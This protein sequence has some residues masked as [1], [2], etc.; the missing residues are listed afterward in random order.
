[1]GRNTELGLVNAVTLRLWMPHGN[2]EGILGSFA[3]ALGAGHAS[4][5][6]K[7]NG[8][9]HYITWQV[10]QGMP[11]GQEQPARNYTNNPMTKHIDEGYMTNMG[12]GAMNGASRYANNAGYLRSECTHKIRL[13]TLQPNETR[14]TT[15]GIDANAI[16]NWWNQRRQTETTYQL[17]SKTH[18]CTGCVTEALHA[19]G[20]GE[21]PRATFVVT[22][23]DVLNWV[24]VEGNKQNLI[25][26]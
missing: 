9:R 16:I 4:L 22:A 3:S 20:L 13:R 14:P 18:N 1:M 21:R 23:A 24:L 15:T 7:L 12:W 19:G 5:T 25:W 10:A 17:I 11:N 8:A 6:V 26:G 2:T